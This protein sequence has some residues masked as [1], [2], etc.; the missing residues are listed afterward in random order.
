MGVNELKTKAI[1]PTDCVF[2]VTMD[3]QLYHEP[4]SSMVHVLVAGTTGSGKSIF[5]NAYLISMLS[6]ATP[7]YH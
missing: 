4:L 5:L 6:P 3:G 7:I 2:G 1:N